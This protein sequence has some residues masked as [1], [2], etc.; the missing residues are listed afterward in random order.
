ML[1]NGD[2]A[3]KVRQKAGILDWC[4]TA[5]ASLLNVVIHANTCLQVTFSIGIMYHYIQLYETFI[6]RLPP[7]NLKKKLNLND[8]KFYFSFIFL[9][10]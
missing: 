3:D 2:E 6:T 7:I 1:F 8:F 10:L 9:S 5:V 4:S